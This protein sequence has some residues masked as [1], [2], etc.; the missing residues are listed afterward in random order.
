MNRF[1]LIIDHEL[2][3]GCRTCEVACKQEMNT[4]Q[5]VRLI[6]VEEDGPKEVDGR[7][8]FAYHVKVCRHCEVPPCAEACPEHA[9]SKREDGIVVMD[10]ERCTGCR[11]CVDKCPYEAITFDMT[12][13][14]AQKCNLCHHRVDEGLL[15]ACADNV[16][17]GHCIDLKGKVTHG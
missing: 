11:T 5:G 2:C 9:I 14:I 1:A 10:Y 8:E 13:G 12:K 7:L 6:S 15:P 16:C 3:W 4:A 17:L